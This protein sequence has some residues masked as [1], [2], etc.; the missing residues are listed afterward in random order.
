MYEFQLL[1]TRSNLKGFLTPFE[2]MIILHRVLIIYFMYNDIYGA[3]L[4]LLIFIAESEWTTKDLRVVQCRY[5]MDRST[6]T[7]MADVREQTRKVWRT[8][9]QGILRRDELTV[10]RGREIYGLSYIVYDM[11]HLRTCMPGL[12]RDVSYLL[13]VFIIDFSFKTICFVLFSGGRR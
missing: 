4:L 2:W 7:Q 10:G 8:D 9:G 1:E 11:S 13:F 3:F 6:I 12:H 5:K